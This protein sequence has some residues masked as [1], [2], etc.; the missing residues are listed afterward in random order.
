MDDII[1]FI[2]SLV[3]KAVLIY[4]CL[5][6]YQL[7]SGQ[8]INFDKSR[9]YFIKIPQPVK[10]QIINVFCCL[11]GELS[12]KYLG[13]PIFSK[14]PNVHTWDFLIQKFEQK[15]S[16][17]KSTLSLAEKVV[18]IKLIF[19]NLPTYIMS[20]FKIPESVINKIEKIIRNFL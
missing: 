18:L 8:K 16:S 9:I 7:G 5:T 17:W 11:E 20:I 4:G 3:N 14:Q 10:D 13:V 12:C 1:I 2:E 6:V 15:L 19:C